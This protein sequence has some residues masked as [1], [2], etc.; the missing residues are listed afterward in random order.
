MDV[1][2]FNNM[3]RQSIDKLKELETIVSLSTT[4]SDNVVET[5]MESRGNIISKMS[6][7][8]LEHEKLVNDTKRVKYAILKNICNLKIFI[9]ML[10]P[11]F[12]SVSIKTANDKHV[13]RK[14]NI[15]TFYNLN[16][17]L[18]ELILKYTSN[19]DNIRNINMEL[20]MLN[21]EVKDSWVK[22]NMIENKA[23]TFNKIS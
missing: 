20:Q 4:F 21:T 3:K 23:I 13:P 6:K 8:N 16:K 22:K 2:I 7:I 11:D 5:F 12:T 10:H 18:N 9:D 1:I 14:M 19:F 17:K 15:E